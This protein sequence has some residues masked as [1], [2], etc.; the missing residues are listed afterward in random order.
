MKKN[1]L[2]LMAF[3][4]LS[5]CRITKTITMIYAKNRATTTESEFINGKHAAV[6]FLKFTPEQNTLAETIWKKEKKDFSEV[7][8]TNENIAPIVYNSELEFRKI[9]NPVQLDNYIKIANKNDDRI[10]K[11]FLNDEQLAEIKRI[12]LEK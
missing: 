12:Y 9:L 7:K 4:V 6:D 11:Y 1:V 8:L 3:L 2:L 5:S 10:I